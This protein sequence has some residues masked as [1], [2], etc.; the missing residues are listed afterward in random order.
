MPYNV[1]VIELDKE[2]LKSKKFRNRNPHLNLRRSCYYVG[3]TT[4]D[5]VSRFKQHKEGYKANRFAKRYGI[6]LAWRKFQKYNPIESREEAEAIE[7]QLTERLRKKGH[8][9]WSN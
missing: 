5:P 9:V 6:R 1:Y 7:R 4:H 8:G 3:Q 2:V